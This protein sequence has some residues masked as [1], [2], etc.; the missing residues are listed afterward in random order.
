LG[1]TELFSERS[2]SSPTSWNAGLVQRLASIPEH[3]YAKTAYEFLKWRI[4]KTVDIYGAIA[5][6]HSTALLLISVQR[7]LSGPFVTYTSSGILS[8]ELIMLEKA[9]AISRS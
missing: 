2:T 8:K 3:L 4:D 5:S 9:M 6:V 1:S 7:A